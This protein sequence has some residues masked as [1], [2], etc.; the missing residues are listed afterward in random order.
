MKGYITISDAATIYGLSRSSVYAAVRTGRIRGSKRVNG[1]LMLPRDGVEAWRDGVR[2]HVTTER[3]EDMKAFNFQ[4]ERSLF[5]ELCTRA[6]NRRMSMTAYCR[7]AIRR[8]I[9][10]DKING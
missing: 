9:E 5:D 2:A 3:T 8:Q 10:E 6:D 1:M 4:M 7:M